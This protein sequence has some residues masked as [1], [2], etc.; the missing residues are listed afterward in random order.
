MSDWNNNYR[1]TPP[2]RP[3]GYYGEE[4]LALWLVGMVF[5]LGTIFLLYK[6]V[7]RMVGLYGWEK[8]V[9]YSIVGIVG[10]LFFSILVY[11]L[12]CGLVAWWDRFF[13]IYPTAGDYKPK[14]VNNT[15]YIAPKNNI[16]KKAARTVKTGGLL[17]GERERA[18]RA[19]F[20]GRID[21]ESKECLGKY[22]EKYLNSFEHRH[23]LKQKEREEALEAGL[24]DE[25]VEPGPG[26]PQ[27]LT[28]IDT[29]G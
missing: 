26:T 8:V 10:I 21:G 3:Y 12:W 11:T 22:E 27:I 9:S 23:W 29:W 15:S 1:Y 14:N 16:I 25:N 17:A 18:P 28:K 7:T 6:L 5:T 4:K 19:Q 24:V 20:F 2:T 13:C